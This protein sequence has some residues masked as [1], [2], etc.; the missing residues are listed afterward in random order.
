M[1][2]RAVVRTSGAAFDRVV[3]TAG[4]RALETSAPA[5]SE[6]MRHAGVALATAIR[7]QLGLLR[8]RPL[9]AL[10]G[11]GDNGGDAL[12]MARALAQTGAAVT[13]WAS[14]DRAEDPLV[15][16]AC[17]AGVRWRVWSGNTRSLRRD[18][19]AATSVIDGLLGIGSNL[20]LH[21]PVAEI[22]GALP[23][24]E[25]Q[26]RLAIDIPTGVDADTGT[27]D[28]TTFR[29][30]T[31]LATG[32]IKIGTLLHPG[33]DHAGLVEALDIGLGQEIATSGAPQLITAQTVQPV[34]PERPLGSHK[35][36]FGTVLILGGSA[37]YR[38]APALAALAAQGS[39]AGL[40]IVA[41]VEEVVRSSVPLT[42]AVVFRVLPE[43][44]NGC[45]CATAADVETLT[46]PSAVLVGPGLG[47]SSDSDALAR[48]IATDSARDITVVIDADGLN[49][50]AEEP[51]RIDALGTNR[52]L[53][54]H[55]GE[56]RRLLGLSETPTGAVLMGHA[57]ALANRSGAVVVAKGS[58]TFVASPG[59][60]HILAQPNPV[61]ATAGSGDV[62]AGIIAGLAG[63]GLPPIDAARLGVWLHAQ[64]AEVAADGR[65]AGLEMA[66]IAHRLAHALLELSN[67]G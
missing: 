59:K 57:Q 63:Q 5:E 28:A 9:I 67:Q 36:T 35:G 53:T 4:M 13:C 38:G 66:E 30:T 40:T 6:L 64:A 26:P 19:L 65:T 12:I 50:L 37:S 20:P 8:G 44:A 55:P 51:D 10:V 47:R 21:G 1:N 34:L 39:G 22:L 17:R 23:P 11:P 56:M 46:S 33:I 42:P 31:T 43:N 16:A 14:R 15:H 62:L 52:I 58:P 45:V 3:N 25:G 41:S 60:M 2:P 49:A 48:S 32:P 24:V 18:V 29:A 54:P 7:H 61:L 27:T